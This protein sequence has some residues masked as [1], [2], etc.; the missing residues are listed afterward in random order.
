M[1]NIELS[2]QAMLSEVVR[3]LGPVYLLYIHE[4]IRETHFRASVSFSAKR[5]HAEADLHVYSANNALFHL[6]NEGIVEIHDYSH[7]LIEQM[8]EADR[9]I[10]AQ[11]LG[12]SSRIDTL[13]AAWAKM[14]A[15]LK[16]THTCC[17]NTVLFQFPI[18]HPSRAQE[19]INAMMIH[20]EHL[21]QS[22]TQVITTSTEQLHEIKQSLFILNHDSKVLFSAEET[23]NKGSNTPQ[24]VTLSPKFIFNEMMEAMNHPRPIYSHACTLEN[25]EVACVEFYPDIAVFISGMPT[26]K[27]CGCSVVSKA[28]AEENAALQAIRFMESD[29]HLHLYDFNRANKELLVEKRRNMLTITSRQSCLIKDTSKKWNFILNRLS[30]T[31]DHIVASIFCE[32]FCNSDTTSKPEAMYIL[33]CMEPITAELKQAFDNAVD[34]FSNYAVCPFDITDPVE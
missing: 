32:E 5:V 6:Q 13:L 21:I 28:D 26:Q 34:I 9:F 4:T 23:P 19:D 31:I 2:S 14:I 20:I 3:Q 29:L 33:S 27:I 22:L 30:V 24:V 18:G 25:T 12:N 1:E 15:T 17:K 16:T 8:K 11:S 10:S 7:I